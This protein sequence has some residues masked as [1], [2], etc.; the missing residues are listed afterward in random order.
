MAETTEKTAETAAE[1]AKKRAPR[2][3]KYF[4]IAF[5][6]V[7]I[8]VAMT[9]SFY[10]MDRRWT[11][12][13]FSFRGM[14]QSDKRIVIV[15]IDDE[16]LAHVGSYPWKRG[17]YR[18]LLKGLFQDKAKVVALDILFPDPSPLPEQDAE[19][20]KGAQEYGDKTTFGIDLALKPGDMEMTV[21]RPY[22]E[23]SKVTKNQGSTSQEGLDA[24]GSVRRVLLF[25]APKAAIDWNEYL[26]DPQRIPSLG[27]STLSM[28]LGK[29]P[30]EVAA[31]V[32]SN[33]FWLNLRG[34]KFYTTDDG[35]EHYDF[36][37]PRISAWKILE[38]KL[39]DPERERLKDSIVLVGSTA[40]GAFDHYPTAFDGAVPGV[41]VHANLIDNVLND[42]W[43]RNVSPLLTVLMVIPMVLLAL[44]LVTLPP[45][46]A[47]LGM[48]GAVALW[49][50]GVYAAFLKLYVVDASAPLVALVVTFLAL[51][52]HRA[53]LEAQQ[54][55]EV[56][57]MFGQY[58]APEIVEVLV[59]D[60]DKLKLGGERRDMTMF[61]LD[62]AHF[63]TI[64]EKMKAENLIQFL[65][66]YLTALT[67]D[68]LR[69]HGVV[70][71]YIG[72]CIMAFWNAPLDDPKHRLNACLAAAE[73]IKTI[74][75][76]NK[77]YVDPSI[78]EKPAVRIGLN[79]GDVVVGNTGSARK[80]QYTVLGDEVNLASRLEGAN[81]FFGSTVMA[82]EGTY[83]GA[84][85][86]VEARVLG[87]VR[88]VGKEI[89]IKVFE[90]LSRKGDLAPEWVK[91]LP[92]Y[93]EG[94]EKF[95]KGEFE[96]ASKEF[97]EALKLVPGDKPSKL[98]LNVCQDYMTIPPQGDW[99]VFNLTSK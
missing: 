85:G 50:G 73:C 54:K 23:L 91:A 20:V 16:S 87:S 89:P 14:E 76:L 68:I 59:K 67:D 32:G 93:S 61:F 36:G 79:S 60:P 19:L 30:D 77:E 28:Y 57:Q 62:I 45:V 69:N 49:I 1:K 55:R 21:N 53:M 35:K 83:K 92:V 27:L 94:V 47:G 31:K 66:T 56:R 38:D 41:E 33:Y 9:G 95:L 46:L 97:Q 37:I 75:R 26:A 51:I 78:P 2:F 63:T 34:Q 40:K 4:C 17:V 90:L 12:A 72:D 71:K 3:P 15:T 74:Q 42:R 70:D 80:L 13:M 7:V 8:V 86:A 44:W 43:L 88:V 52:V 18:R 11:D 48:L 10:N 5:T 22:P 25:N 29:T 39:E 82:S 24:D 96:N 65:N 98:Y 99:K 84:E 58:V 81:K 64:S 6:I